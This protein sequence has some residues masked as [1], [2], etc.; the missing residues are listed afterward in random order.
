MRRI[1]GYVIFAVGCLLIFLGPLLYL[2]TKPR[3]EK[4]PI[5]VYD[6]TV[7]TGSAKVFSGQLLRLVGPFPAENISIAKSN[8]SAS[9]EDVAVISIFNRARNLQ[10]SKDFNYDYTIYSMDRTT[11]EEVRCSCG[12]T[13]GIRGLTLKF[14][15]GTKPRTYSFYD[16]TA[17][18][19]FPARYVRTDTVEGLTVYLFRSDVPAT[20][21]GTLDLPGALLGAGKGL[22]PTDRWYSA[23]TSLWVEPITGAVVKAGQISGQWTTYQGKYAVTLA[24]TNFVNDRPSV[25]HTAEQIRTKV[26]QLRLVELWV[27]FFGPILAVILI[28]LGLILLRP[29]RPSRPS[30]EPT[31]AEAFA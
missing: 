6:R 21:I 7:S 20:K 22:F 8:R 27:P 10:T 14:P 9:S 29:L 17:R 24:Q 25:A 26:Y 28:V 4:A 13:P 31:P 30:L 3:V 5:D 15:F 18:K 19:P 1:F 2:Y 23:T 12:E 11:G 16:S